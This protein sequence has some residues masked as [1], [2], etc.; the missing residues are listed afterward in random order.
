MK[1]LQA[2]RS[3]T[4]LME[5]AQEAVVRAGRLLHEHWREF[6]EAGVGF[7]GPVDLVTE[8]DRRSEATIL[9]VIRS[10]YPDDAILT[11][12]RG[13]V[14]RESEYRWL[15]DPLDGTTNYAH[16]LPVFAVSV[17]VERQGQL[18]AGSVYEPATGRLYV[19]GRGE[20]ARRD[21]RVL[22][23]SGTRELDRSLLATGFAYNLRETDETNLDHFDHFSRRAQGIRRLGAAA[24]DLCWVAEGWFDGFWE[25]RLHPWDVAAGVLLVQEAGGRVTDFFG[26]PLDLCRPTLDVVASNGQIH[27]AMLRV[28]ELGHTGMHRASSSTP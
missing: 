13:A 16:G 1:T 4:E 23:V 14:G 17:A 5:T 10:R 11:E 9:E 3:I 8:G 24:L 28:L 12:E 6:L 25:Y 2:S 22:R 18:L 7:K 26:A 20:G 27:G 19:A 15:V 21:G